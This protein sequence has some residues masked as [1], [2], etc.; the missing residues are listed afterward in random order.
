MVLEQLR[1]GASRQLSAFDEGTRNL[2]LVLCLPLVDGVFATLLVTGAFQTFSDMVAIALTVFTGAG[3][4]A[5]L[6]SYADTSREARKMVFRVAPLL[7]AGAVLEALVAPVFEQMFYV[8]RLKYAAGLA[9]LAISAQ[10][11]GVKMSDR[12][13]VPAIILTGLVVSLR[14]PAAFA[15]SL[16]YVAPAVFTAAVA[17]ASLYLSTYLLNHRMRLRY[18]RRGGSIVLLIISLSM[19]GLELPSELGLAVFA[20]SV[21][22]SIRRS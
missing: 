2:L 13:P 4:V 15:L 20:A 22:A 17:V 5:V 1:D 9:L 16:G 14:S 10:L 8:G 11:S 21:L 6:Y 7:L 3:A 19:F 12:F 18:I